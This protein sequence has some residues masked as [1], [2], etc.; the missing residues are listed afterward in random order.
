MPIFY[1]FRGND[2]LVDNLR[3]CYFYRTHAVL[4]KPPDPHFKGTPLFDF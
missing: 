1:R 3:F 2:L 4:L